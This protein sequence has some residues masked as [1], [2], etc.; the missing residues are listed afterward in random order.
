MIVTKKSCRTTLRTLRGFPALKEA[1]RQSYPFVTEA[2]GM[3]G[4]GAG[5]REGL[6]RTRAFLT[7]L[8]RYGTTPFL[9]SMY[10]S[11]ELPQAFCRLCAVFE[12][13]YILRKPVSSLVVHSPS[14]TCRGLLSEGQRFT[15]SH[16]VMSAS[17]APQEYLPQ[18]GP[19]QGVS[20][21]IFLTDRPLPM[22]K[23]KLTRSRPAK[24]G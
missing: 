19:L 5:C 14:R 22:K 23:G 20:R 21:A 15:C 2:I 3:V 9:F 12:G 1:D 17:Q 13:I 10:G 24:G 16:L 7:S 6:E 11:G 4:D 18:D 8:G